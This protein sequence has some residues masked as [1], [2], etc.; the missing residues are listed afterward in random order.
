MKTETTFFAVEI[1][2]ETNTMVT[3]SNLSLFYL[4]SPLVMSVSGLQ[5]VKLYF[6]LLDNGG[7]L[8]E[9]YL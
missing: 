7:S 3:A 2:L 1:G 5:L 4:C 6:S 8:V 9:T